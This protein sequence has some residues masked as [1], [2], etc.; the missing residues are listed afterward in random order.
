MPKSALRY[1]QL[2]RVIKVL[3]LLETSRFGKTVN[4][5]RDDLVDY[6]GLADL[7]ARTVRRDLQFLQDAGF[8]V[9]EATTARGRVWRL[10]L[11][12]NRLKTPFQDVS[13]LELLAFAAGRELLM[14]LAGTPYW[15]GIETLWQRIKTSLPASVW[16][17]F[18]REKSGLIVRAPAAVRYRNKDG[19]LSA[20]NRAIC[21]HR[22]LEIHYQG[23]A[24]RKPERRIVEPYAL[25]LYQGSLFLVGTAADK[26]ND[27]RV[28][29]FKLDRLAKAKL[30]DKRFT[31]RPDFDPERLFASSIGIYQGTAPQSFLIRFDAE[32]AQWVEET[33]FH[34][35]QEMRKLPDGG[36]EVRIMEAYEAEVIPRVMGLGIHAEVLEPESCRESLGSQFKRLM[37]RYLR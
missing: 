26:P 6:L 21:E 23:L 14:P 36:V 4:E 31:P 20:L 24:Q 15:T 7:S 3:T 9:D 17:T 13:V 19:M 22:V 25:V 28:R 35:H 10:D 37:E 5:L 2:A 1:A 8:H 34:P 27:L 30:L 33:P 29:Q 12:L 18:E 11:S 32:V 16:E